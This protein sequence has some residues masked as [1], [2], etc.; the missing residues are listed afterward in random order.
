MNIKNSIL[1]LFLGLPFF[2]F[3]QDVIYTIGGDELKSK[4][5]E[6]LD[7]DIKYRKFDFLDGPI[8]SM[9][10]SKI[11]MIIYKNGQKEKFVIAPQDPKVEKTETEQ[12]APPKQKISNNKKPKPKVEVAEEPTEQTNDEETPVEKPVQKPKNGKK[13]LLEKSEPDSKSLKNDDENSVE[14]SIKTGQSTQTILA[15]PSKSANASI[16][17]Q[18]I[19][20]K[21]KTKNA[22]AANKKIEKET[23][24][25]PVESEP[26]MQKNS[27][28]IDSNYRRSSLYTMMITDPSRQNEE[29]IKSYFVDKLTPDKY[30][31]HNLD[32]RFISASA[33][34][35]ELDNIVEHLNR[36]KIAHQLI[37]KWFSRSPK[38]DFNMKMIKNR[39]Y[40]DASVMNIKKAKNSVKGNAILAQ[41]GEELVGNTFILINDSKYIN[42][43]DVGKV[44]NGAITMLSN[45]LGLLGSLVAKTAV[46]TMAKGYIVSTSSHLFKLV[47]DAETQQRFYDELYFDA[48][49]MTPANKA[50]IE[51]KIAAFDNADFFA[52]D[53][54]GTDKS[55]ADVQ[56][57]AFTTKTNGELIGRATIKTIDNIISKL[58]AEYDVFKT[59]TPIFEGDPLS[60]KI[61]LKEGLTAKTKFEV[62]E[63][64]LGEDGTT[65]YVKVGLVK[66]DPNYSIWDNRYGADEENKSQETDR[67]YFKPISGSEFFPGQL[68]RQL[69]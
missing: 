5:I 30:N 23:P 61:G 4:V 28:E 6:I 17:E 46:Q 29:D 22:I 68:L 55:S 52:L 50:E 34:K 21:P 18:T 45:R 39:G 58:Q 49:E 41:A 16:T 15:K 33:E 38:G 19:L 12:V 56:S 14:T 32:E 13:A 53:Y 48:S 64:Q 51:R 57:T 9:S 37:S 44:A 31:N 25:E 3:S 26:I 8:Y 36:N 7:N 60:A 40:Y 47:W 2:V 54:I 69:K 65:S 35:S 11:Y 27:G 42:K 20:E 67:T 43:E 63:K 62:L 1:T 10:K 24:E 59:K 66:V